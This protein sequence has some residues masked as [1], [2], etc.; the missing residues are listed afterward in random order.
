MLVPAWPC[1]PNATLGI[2][3][4]DAVTAVAARAS[5]VQQ[6]TCVGQCSVLELEVEYGRHD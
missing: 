3:M 4:Q 6:L 2:P 5:A 1:A